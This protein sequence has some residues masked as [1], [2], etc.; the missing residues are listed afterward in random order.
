MI[1]IFLDALVDSAKML[2]L[3]LLVYIGIELLEY[4]LGNK[5]RKSIQKVGSA[6]PL[7]GAAAGALPQCGFSVITTALYSQRLVTIGTL[8]AVYLSTSD[9]AIPVILSQPDK[10]S[11]LLPLILTKVGIAIFA[12][13]TID[14][15]FRKRNKQTLLHI[16][17]YQRGND[18]PSHHHES[19]IDKTA[20]CGHHTCANPKKFQFK[21]LF[22]HPLIHTLKI[23]SFILIVS[24]AINFLFFKLGD[25]LISKL[26]LNNS[27]FQPILAALVG[28]IPNCASS[29]AITELYLKGV[30]SYGSVVAGL[31]ASGGLGLLV[32]YK[33]EKKQ[34]EVWKIVGLLFLISVLA[35]ITIQL[36]GL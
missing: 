4:K 14:F 8:L 32:L 11:I 9:E 5:M 26:F 31:C 23:F 21:E 35:G 7:L 20:C 15:L 3:L 27:I 30:I 22:I 24:F 2:P 18:D 10:A 1:E 12:G 17:S 25:P 28:L 13:Y 6:G 34:R 29:V 33:E 16:Q 19:V 36:L